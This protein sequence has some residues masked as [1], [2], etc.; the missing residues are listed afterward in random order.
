MDY[1]WICVSLILIM[2]ASDKL[3]D[4]AASIALKLKVPKILV[5]LTIMSFG[6]CMPELSISFSSMLSGN[7]S[8]SLANVIGSCVVNV[9]LVI[10]IAAL[11]RPI[12]MKDGTVKSELPLLLLTTSVFCILLANRLLSNETFKFL[13]RIDGILILLVFLMFIVYLRKLIVNNDKRKER[14]TPKYNLVVSI[15]LCLLTL[16]VIY[17]ASELL[18]K[19]AVNVAD[20]FGISEKVITMVVIVIGTCLP[21]LIV[22][23]TAALK[24]EFDMAIG[25]II[26]TN[27]FNICVVL[28]LPLAIFGKLQIV[29]FD[30]IDIFAVFFATILLY[31][32][33]KSS[34]SLSKIE[35]VLLLSMFIVYY[36]FVIFL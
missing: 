6:T 24:K 16:V 21:E 15:L 25:N 8:I 18:V 28:G 3:I 10:G 20:S 17:F 32:F 19:S 26:G 36:F 22:T 4:A 1:L 13:Y 5:A 33:S 12:E 29:D 14:G 27:I 11:I 7:A 2:L 30:F 23:V 35:G 9:F 31:G 34:K